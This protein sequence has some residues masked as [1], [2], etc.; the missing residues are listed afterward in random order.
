MKT[1]AI[2]A[3]ACRVLEESIYIKVEVGFKSHIR[4]GKASF[5]RRLQQ[6]LSGNEDGTFLL[7][8]N[9]SGQQAA[10]EERRPALPCTRGSVR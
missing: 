1:A 6:S 8:G 4:L 9:W 5:R 10:R 7:R 2:A 3:A